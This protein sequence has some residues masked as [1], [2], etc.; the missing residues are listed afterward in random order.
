MFVIDPFLAPFFQTALK[1]IA[2][3]TKPLNDINLLRTTFDIDEK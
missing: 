3:T 1:S 2:E